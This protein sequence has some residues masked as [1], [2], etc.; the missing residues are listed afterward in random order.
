M[1]K[2]TSELQD[3]W[4]ESAP[5]RVA[6]DFGSEGMIRPTV[7]PPSTLQRRRELYLSSQVQ[8]GRALEAPEGGVS[9]NPSAE[10]HQR[11]LEMAVDE[12]KERLLKEAKDE[13]RIRALSEVVNARRQAVGGNE[14]VDG[15]A[16]GPGDAGSD[17]EASEAAEER[18][19]KP[20]KRKT[21][22]QRNKKLRARETARLAALESTQRRIIK[23]IASVPALQSSLEKREK[24]LAEADRL[25][26][27]AKR[28]RERLGLE[29]GEK[30]G[31]HRVGKGSVAVQLGEDLAETLRQIKVGL[32]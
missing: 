4:T 5:I 30:V 13:E 19:T 24:A 17:A 28:E 8:G 2:T 7:K 20:T 32:Q 1:K 18:R 12:E 27:M 9:Y 23:S 11:L 14:L 21:Q 29:G 31:K 15:M 26:K 16:I 10:S 25:A 6:S 22:A 3:A